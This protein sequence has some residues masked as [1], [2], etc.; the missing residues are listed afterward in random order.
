[1]AKKTGFAVMSKTRQFEISSKGGKTGHERGTAHEWTR[2]AASVAGRKGG[3]A[4]AQ[5][6]REA[7]HQR[8]LDA[9]L[10]GTD[11]PSV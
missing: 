11:T 10:A 7:R 6:K 5:R 8:H 2:E 3:L 1:M 9:G 4:T